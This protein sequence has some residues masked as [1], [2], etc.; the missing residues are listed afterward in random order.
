MTNRF[1]HDPV[2]CDGAARPLPEPQTIEI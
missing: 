2:H 1:Q